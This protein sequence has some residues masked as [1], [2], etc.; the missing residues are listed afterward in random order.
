MRGCVEEKTKNRYVEEGEE[1]G[2]GGEEKSVRGGL[3]I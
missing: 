2:E 3:R 1:E